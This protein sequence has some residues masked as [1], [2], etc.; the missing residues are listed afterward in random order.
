MDGLRS[1]IKVDKHSAGAVDVGGLRRGT[2]SIQVKKPK[3]SEA[4]PEAVIRDGAELTL[5]AEEVG[6][7]RTFVDTKHVELESWGLPL[8]D[9]G[10]H[11]FFQYIHY[12]ELHETAGT[13]KPGDSQEARALR[14]M[15]AA[16]DRDAEFYD[17]SYQKYVQGRT[18][19]LGIVGRTP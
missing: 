4:F 8:V 7:L 3:F 16:R 13:K 5:R 17:P 6:L 2:K 15:K 10:W 12:K 14:A 19:T 11:A 1:F 18:R 9:A